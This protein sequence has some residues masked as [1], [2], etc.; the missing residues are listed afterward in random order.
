[1]RQTIALLSLLLFAA[2]D[3]P[4]ATEVG[5]NTN[6]LQSCDHDRDCTDSLA[7]HCGICTLDCNAAA[8]CESLPAARC[9][10]PDDPAAWATCQSR[11]PTLSSG[12]C[13]PGCEPGTCGTGDACVSGSCVPAPLPQ[14][15][16]CAPAVE[17]SDVNRASEDAL[18]ALVQG[19]R[20]DGNTVCGSDPPSARVPP[21]R[22]DRRLRCAARVLSMDL[23]ETGDLGLI[24][25]LGRNTQERLT[26]VGYST[27]FWGES[28]A[29]EVTAAEALAIMLTDVDSCQR[30]VDAEFLD[31][32]IGAAGEVQIVTIGAE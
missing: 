18:L 15:E 8:E 3:G 14:S 30:F 7:C 32:G 6:W 23:N 22:L 26:L 27:T 1:M 10:L 16:F 4:G 31:V 29:R 25:S 20:A 17:R 2:C 9:V 12:I 11:E 19:V 28:Y 21:L 13:L 5:S 24:D